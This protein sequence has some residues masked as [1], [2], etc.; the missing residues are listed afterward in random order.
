MSTSNQI[1]NYRVG[2]LMAL[3]TISP[4]AA[5]WLYTPSPRNDQEERGDITVQN[6][7]WMAIA[8]AGAFAIAVILYNKFRTKANNLDVD[9]PGA[10]P[11]G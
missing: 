10:L 6:V 3:D 4:K 9:T 11:V 8:A 5:E 7:I 1:L 2:A